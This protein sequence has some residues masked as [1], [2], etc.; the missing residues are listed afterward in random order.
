VPLDPAL[1]I[2]LGSTPLALEIANQLNLLRLISRLAPLLLQHGERGYDIAAPQPAIE[3][4]QQLGLGCL[5][6]A[7]AVILSCA[8][9]AGAHSLLDNG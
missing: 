2:V 4:L 3:P 6:G 8:A 7:D 1:S 5:V 9:L